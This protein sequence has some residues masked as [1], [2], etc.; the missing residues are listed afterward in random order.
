MIND[1]D[2]KYRTLALIETASK[3]TFWDNVVQLNRSESE[4]TALED[5]DIS[6][7]RKKWG[8]GRLHHI[9]LFLH[10]IFIVTILDHHKS[11]ENQSRFDAYS[12]RYLC[13]LNMPVFWAESNFVQKRNFMR[14][15]G[16]KKGS[17]TGQGGDTDSQLNSRFRNGYAPIRPSKKC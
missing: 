6:K 13:R 11:L 12:P 7:I 14:Y 1:I 10:D 17:T 9:F 5:L 16:R 8:A 15:R 2:K 4:L 3:F